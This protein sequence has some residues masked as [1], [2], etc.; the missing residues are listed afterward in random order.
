M[1][2]I[3]GEQRKQKD[4]AVEAEPHRDEEENG[5]GE[6]AVPEDPEIDDGMLIRRR[7]LPPEHGN[8]R[9]RGDDAEPD[10]QRVIEPILLAAFLEHVLE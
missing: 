2:Q 4:A 10:D 7:Q 8:E 1:Q 3:L 9:H 6:V 5:A